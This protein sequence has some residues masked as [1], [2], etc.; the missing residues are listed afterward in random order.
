[1]KKHKVKY[2]KVVQTGIFFFQII[3][4]IKIIIS[5]AINQKHIY[6]RVTK[7]QCLKPLV[8]SPKPMFRQ[9][10][11]KFSGLQDEQPTD[12]VS[13]AVFN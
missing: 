9:L 8:I 12:I 1:M 13:V 3:S 2:M 5:E 10:R 7:R 11:K 6:V 4:K